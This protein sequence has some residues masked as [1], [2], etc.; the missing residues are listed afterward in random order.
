MY[1]DIFYLSTEELKEGKTT[2]DRQTVVSNEGLLTKSLNKK[3]C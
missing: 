1:S 3:R 2:K